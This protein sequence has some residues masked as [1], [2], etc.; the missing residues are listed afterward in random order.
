ML[1]KLKQACSPFPLGEDRVD[2]PAVSAY[3]LGGHT[4]TFFA[5]S[6]GMSDVL[7]LANQSTWGS[8]GSYRIERETQLGDTHSG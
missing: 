2:S 1:G 8:L 6:A 5:V 3:V 4:F 7:A